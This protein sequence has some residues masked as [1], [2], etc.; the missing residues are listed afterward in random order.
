MGIVSHTLLEVVKEGD[1]NMGSF[2]IVQPS[3]FGV[4][5]PLKSDFFKD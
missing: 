5:K 4:V 1:G 2:S 3:G